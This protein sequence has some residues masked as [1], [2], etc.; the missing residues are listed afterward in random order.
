MT[1]PLNIALLCHPT[2]GG[3]GILATELGHELAERG[4]EV[5]VISERPP[6][7]LTNRHPRIHFCES[8]P[9]EFPLFTSPDHTLPLATRIAEVCRSHRIDVVHAHYAIP[10]TAAAWIAKQLIGPSAPPTITTLHGTDIVYLGAMAEYRTLLQ[11][12]LEAS[13]LVT[14]VSKNLKQRT[15]ELFQLGKEIVVIPNFYEPRPVTETREQVRANLSIG[16]DE[17]LALHASNLRSIKR[18]DLLLDSFKTALTRQPAKLLILAGADSIRLEEQIAERK[19]QADVIVKDDVFDVDNYYAAADFTL[20]ASEY[21]SFCL[22]ILEGMRYGLPSASFAVGGIP[23]VV[24]DQETGFLAPFGD[25]GRLAEHIATLAGNQDLRST[26]GSKARQRAIENFSAP[27]VV[28][29]YLEAYQ[30]VMGT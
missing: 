9:V 8:T 16:N 18:L 28:S 22:G 10:H 14:C 19:L 26:M 25:T 4:H 20:Y 11:H 2:I 21:E 7:R 1:Q 3:S 12:V 30:Q 15:Q 13:D 5:Y 17:P 23:E 24:L 6:Y 29:Q 27:S